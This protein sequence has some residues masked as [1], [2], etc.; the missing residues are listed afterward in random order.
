MRNNHDIIERSTAKFCYNCGSLI[1]IMPK[2]DKP[3]HCGDC[4]PYRA[5]IQ[6]ADEQLRMHLSRRNDALRRLDEIKRDRKIGI[7]RAQQRN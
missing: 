1:A 4:E 6:G 2:N 5:L 3:Q 7:E